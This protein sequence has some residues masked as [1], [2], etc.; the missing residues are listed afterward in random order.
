M[1][2]ALKRKY[3]ILVISSASRRLSCMHAWTFDF[4]YCFDPF[5]LKRRCCVERELKGTRFV[6]CKRAWRRSKN[7]LFFARIF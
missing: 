1:G 3:Q 6:L 5:C 4:L 7:I 2:E